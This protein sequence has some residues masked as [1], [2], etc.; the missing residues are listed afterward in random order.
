MCSPC[1]TS[2]TVGGRSRGAALSRQGCK[3][4]ACNLRGRLSRTCPLPRPAAGDRCNRPGFL[5]SVGTAWHLMEP[6][7]TLLLVGGTSDIGRATALHYAQAGWRVQLAARNEEEAR[8]NADDIARSHRRRGDG[9]PARHSRDRALREL[10]S[11]ACRRCLIRW[12]ALSANWAIRRKRP[13]P[14]LAHASLVLRTN[15]EGP[16]LLLGILRRALPGARIRHSRGREFRGRRSRAR[17]QLSLW[18]RQGGLHG[19]PVRPA[20]PL[21]APRA[22]GS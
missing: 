5:A 12:C 13:E 8:R 14:I 20:Q 1:S 7:K 21:G 2:L 6:S 17:L 9:A 3:A 22:C 15:F 4:I 18:R 19:V 10:C 16:A 11:T